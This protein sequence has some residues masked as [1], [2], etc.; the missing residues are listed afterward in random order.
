MTTSSYVSSFIQQVLSKNNIKVNLSGIGAD[1]LF[2]GYYH[3]H[4]YY[5]KSLIYSKNYKQNFDYWKSKIYPYVRNPF[6]KEKKF[7]MNK[8][9]LLDSLLNYKVNDE[10]TEN[11][12]I[13][14][15]Y[16]F[17]EKNYSKNFLKNRMFNE[18]FFENIPTMLHE[19]D[20]NHMFYSIENRSPFLNREIVELAFSLP[21]N[22]LIHKGF[23]KYILRDAFKGKI[24]KKILFNF[25]KKGFNYNL[26]KIIKN[27]KN[28]DKI[29][30]IFFDKTNPIYEY[31]NYNKINK[32]IVN[33]NS[34][35]NSDIKFLFS[36]INTAIF[37][38]KI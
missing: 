11:L 23:T 30:N 22:F 8:K 19:D 16:K 10:I 37:L 20:R 36:I 25:E 21:P 34:N 6:L 2:S 9:N 35:K 38:K 32:Y 5:L 18:A 1:E 14:Y 12:S 17:I 26:N 31:L 24:N 15:N 29:K 4:A 7:F 28:F 27:S 13:N 33:E 3:H